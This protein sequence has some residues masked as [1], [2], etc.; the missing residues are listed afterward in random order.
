M[1]QTAYLVLN[2]GSSS[3]KFCLI[4][5]QHFQTLLTGLAECLNSPDA[6]LKIKNQ[7][8]GQL[9]ILQLGDADHQLIL[10]ALLTQIELL[11]PELRLIGVGHRVVHGGEKFK[12]ATLVTDEVK[13]QIASCNALAPLHNP[14]NLLGITQIAS[15]MP[16]VPQ[17]AVFDTAFHQSMPE[18]AYLYPVPY[19]Y[20]LE[21]GVRK[22][23]FHGTSHEFVAL[24]AIQR[25]ALNPDRSGIIT[26]H[27]GNGSS[28]CAISNG[29]SVDTSM[30]LTPLE[31]V[32]MGTRSGDVDPGL[33]AYLAERLNITLAQV[34]DILNKQSGLLGLS[35]KT[36]DMRKICALAERQDQQ[37][38][39]ALE[40][41]CYRLAKQIAALSVALTQLDAIVF[42][43]GIGE[44]SAIVRAKTIQHLRVFGALLDSGFNQEHGNDSGIISPLHAAIT[45]LVIPTNEELMIAEQTKNIIEQL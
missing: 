35:G 41:F 7:I 15:L 1:N 19:T 44:N 29:Q 2:S 24:Q 36:N 38:M 8:N 10:K 11:I 20:Y 39:I 12:S 26:A 9:T 37:A 42:T 25:L 6:N 30:G 40:V 13:Q 17:V 3:L 22:Y 4:S 31:G 28:V 23:G 14:A 5:G 32:V 34:T 33:H 18:H 45:I 43:G 16:D 21:L 27:L